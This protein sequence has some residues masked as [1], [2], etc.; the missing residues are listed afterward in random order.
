[1][2]LEG[3]LSLVRCTR[4]SRLIDAQ[5][6][7]GRMR[8][9]LQGFDPGLPGTI[10]VNG[11]GQAGMTLNVDGATPGYVFREGQFFSIVTS[12]VHHLYKLRTETIANDAGQAALPIG[13]MLRVQHLDNDVCHFGVPMIE[14]FIQGD[15]RAWEAAIANFTNV[16]FEIRERK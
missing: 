16:D 13:P 8:W 7:G 10:L 6:E 15:Q 2:L 4:V 1:V 3:R 9:P 12:G 11:A 5:Q 14:G